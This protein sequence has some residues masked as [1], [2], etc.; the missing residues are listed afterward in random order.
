MST[1]I[2]STKQYLLGW[3]FLD[4]SKVPVYVSFLEHTQQT[5]SQQKYKEPMVDV[6][7]TPES[8]YT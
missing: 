8:L 6:K 5:E 4:K 1:I 7:F 2:F 3:E